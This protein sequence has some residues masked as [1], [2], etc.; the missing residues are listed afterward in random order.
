M[1]NVVPACHRCNMSKGVND[2]EVWLGQQ[3]SVVCKALD[4]I[5]RHRAEALLSLIPR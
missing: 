3:G 5:A 1:E 4:R 2:L